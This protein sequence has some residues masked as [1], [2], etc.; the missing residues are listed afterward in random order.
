M[1]R[2]RRLALV[3]VTG[4]LLLTAC[5]GLPTSG[6]VSVG[7]ELGDT[8]DDPYFTQVAD[9]PVKG[10]SPEAIVAG[11]LDAAVTPT[12]N[13]QV[14][15][16]FLTPKFAPD[17]KPNE[18]VTIDSSAA[19]RT[20]SS[21][22]TGDDEDATSAAVEVRL[23]T[24]VA[25]VDATGA[26][27]PATGSTQPATFRLSREKGGEWRIA[28]APDGIVLDRVIFPRVYNPYSLQFFDPAWTHVVPD[29]RWFPRRG[30]IAT[31]LTQA[32]IDGAPSPWLA[33]GVRSAFTGE[34][35]LAVSAVLVDPAQVA[36]VALTR[37]ALVLDATRLARMRTQLEET[38]K[39]L[40]IT[41]VRLTVDG[42]SLDAGRVTLDQVVPEPGTLVLTEKGFG[43][44]EQ[45]TPV[46][47]ITAQL[48]KIPEPITAI[49]VAADD[50]QAAV[51]LGSGDVHLVSAGANDQLDGRSGLIAPSLDPFGYVWTVPRDQPGAL[52][53]IGADVVEHPIAHAWQDASGISQLRVSPDGARVAAVITSGG[54]R[55]VVVAAVVRDDKGVP[56]QLGEP[57]QLSRLPAAAQ[58]LGWLGGDSLVILD[59]ANDPILITQQIGGPASQKPAPAGSASLSGARSAPGVRVLTSTGVVFAQR[60]STWQEA[61]EGVLVL[62]TRA[63]Q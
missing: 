48:A 42:R 27:A 39:P 57:Q 13:W 47:Q 53:A 55:K 37:P 51:Q 40:G 49:D 7:L 33:D 54:A 63:G 15:R 59:D 61:V 9:G 8:P 43:I 4:M 45:L 30:T 62:G 52:M 29:V 5:S 21:D 58:G 50:S 36:D 60:G 35:G 31:T 26:Y 56:T 22:V 38:L 19:D 2:L 44:G 20:I 34:V 11:F 28:E 14:A 10:A 25:N 46:G 41:E 12:D 17:W 23:E 24:V 3:L 32:V 18:G 1:T 6:P 16:R